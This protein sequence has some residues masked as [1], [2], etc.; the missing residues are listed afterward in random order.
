MTLLTIGW[1]EDVAVGNE[2]LQGCC[3]FEKNE[4]LTNCFVIQ[5]L[6]SITSV[7]SRDKK[8]KDV[9]HKG[10]NRSIMYYI[11]MVHWISLY[12]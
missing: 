11:R 1:L 8:A 9:E 7:S 4:L 6:L 5:A 2:F 10:Y 12:I 3:S